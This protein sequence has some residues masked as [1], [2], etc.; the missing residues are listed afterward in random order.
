MSKLISLG[1]SLIDFTLFEQNNKFIVYCVGGATA[2]VAV[3]FRRLEGESAFIG[4]VSSDALGDRIVH[5]LTEENVN[6]NWIVR[7]DEHRTAITIISVTETGERSFSFYHDNSA[8]LQFSQEKLSFE[9]FNN[10]DILHFCSSGLLNYPIKNAHVAALR[11]AKEKEVIV[12]FDVNVRLNL[13]NSAE[14]CK[15]E[16]L[17]ILPF[18]DILKVS[19][20]E[21]RFLCAN[22]IELEAIKMLYQSS[23]A[24]KYIFVTYG[25][26]GASVYDRSGRCYHTT[27]YIV[28]AIDTTAAGDSFIAAIDYCIL[29]GSMEFNDIIKSLDFAVA[30]AA[31]TTTR[32]GSISAL[33]TKKEVLQFIATGRKYD[34]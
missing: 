14:Q 30:A 5:A 10:G 22:Q 9:A 13:W 23:P 17:N 28:D 1:E 2:N 33:P 3:A 32:R 19:E 8:D 21:L 15:K 6:I 29:K 12:S 34:Y 16:I 24:I 27:A 26:R 7:S 18:V 4:E 11:L 31:I 20:E 25:E